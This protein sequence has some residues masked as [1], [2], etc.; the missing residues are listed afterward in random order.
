MH[1]APALIADIDCWDMPMALAGGRTL[2]VVPIVNIEGRDYIADSGSFD[3][4]KNLGTPDQVD[5]NRNW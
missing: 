2:Q 5:L 4:R 1:N 3:Q